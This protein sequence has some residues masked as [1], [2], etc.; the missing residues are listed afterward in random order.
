MILGL[1]GSWE[2]QADSRNEKTILGACRLLGFACEIPGVHILIPGET[3]LLEEGNLGLGAESFYRILGTNILFLGLRLVPGTTE[4]V[5]GMGNHIRIRWDNKGCYS[6][7]ADNAENRSVN[8]SASTTFSL[9]KIT[10]KETSTIGQN[11]V[12]DYTVRS[13]VKPDKKSGGGTDYCTS[14]GRPRG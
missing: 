5:P 2:V 11:I 13:N 3:L 12:I 6:Y 14:T 10:C 1:K 7:K 9:Q 4:S 8:E